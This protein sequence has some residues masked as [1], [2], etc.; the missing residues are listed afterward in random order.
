M[1][2]IRHAEQ[3]VTVS[4][5]SAAPRV[6]AEM[7]H[8]NIIEC[9]GVVLEGERIAFVG[10]HAEAEA[11]VRGLEFDRRQELHIL[12]A[13]GKTVIPGLVDP[14][15]HLVY[16]GSR[17]SELGLRLQGATYMDILK[18]GGGILYTTEQTR[19]ATEQELKEAA[20]I[21]LNRFLEHGVTTVE[22]KSGYGL[23]T[24]DEL[25]QLR[26]ARALHAE[27]PIELVSTFMGAH[28][29]PSEYKASPESYVQLLIEEMIPAVAEQQLAEYCDVFCEKGVFTP[30]Q[31]R[32]ILLAGLR[33]GLKPKIHADEIVNT[34]G[35]ELASEVGAISAEHLLCASTRGIEVMAAAGVIAVLLP[36]TAFYLMARPADAR[37][38]IDRGVPVAL[39]TDCNP[40]SSPTTSLPLIMNLA[41]LT[42]KM[43]PAEALTACTINAAHAI[44][45][46]ERIGSIEVG[47]Q[48]DL[49]IL[50]APSYTFMS[51]HYGVNL[52]STVIKKGVPVVLGG[53]RIRSMAATAGDSWPQ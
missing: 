5:S 44:G 27:H 39:S 14:H 22:A 48:A 6:G 37:G 41:C 17:E 13:T 42:M 12:D 29:I 53:K 18:A 33:H 20:V 2:Y 31:S 25:K 49:V 50:D 36:G 11:Y 26:V 35:A 3:I 30:E 32:E 21:R 38:M 10:H 24:A 46:A 34:G 15:T 4:G 40:G 43:T 1:L 45:R 47:K 52:T 7:N 19:Q 51:Y 16:A 8:L 9:G 28:A 23:C